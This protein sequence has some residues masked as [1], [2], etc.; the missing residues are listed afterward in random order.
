MNLA[1]RLGYRPDDRV[2]IVHADDVGVT[3]AAN[4]AAF[5]GM[6]RGSITCGSVLVPCPWFLEAAEY[7]RSHRDADL[8][9]HLTLTCEYPLYRWRPLSGREQAPTLYDEQGFMWA[10][11]EEA[12]AHVS[13]EDAA[14]EMRAQI[15]AAL[16]AG[17]DVTHLDTHMGTV[18]YPGFV[19]S[20]ISL[21]AEYRLPLFIIRPTRKLLEE[22]GMLGLWDAL[23]P[24]AQQIDKSGLPVLDAITTETLGHPIDEKEAYFKGL[25][26]GLEPGVTHFLIHPAKPS[27]EVSFLSVEAAGRVRDY[28]LFRDSS[29]RSY[30]EALGIHL[31]G[32]R[33]IREA[34]RT[35]ALKS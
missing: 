22:R 10:S 15:D 9:V 11:T 27:E 28:E 7:G 21:A 25:F 12:V 32:Y 23:Q 26:D 4:Q 3:H 2:L 1:E 8:G 19:E 24:V 31:T 33:E 5:E 35:G 16:N 6:E 13:P 17:I 18:M 30:V 29:M 34:Y 20:Y 14:L